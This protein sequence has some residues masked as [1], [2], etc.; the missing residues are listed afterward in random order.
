MRFSDLI[1]AVVVLLTNLHHHILSSSFVAGRSHVHAFVSP[2]STHSAV[3]TVHQH[4]MRANLECTVHLSAQPGCALECT[5]H[6]SALSSLS[7]G[8]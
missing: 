6:L 4:Q 2:H 7:T 3:S 5:V 8:H 1:T